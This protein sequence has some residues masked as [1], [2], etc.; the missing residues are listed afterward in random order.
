MFLIIL[1]ILGI[2]EGSRRRDITEKQMVSQ[3]QLVE[4]VGTRWKIKRKLSTWYTARGSGSNP[5][6]PLLLLHILIRSQFCLFHSKLPWD[7][8]KQCVFFLAGNSLE[9][10]HFQHCERSEHPSFSNKIWIFAPKINTRICSCNANFG[11]K[12]QM[13]QITLC[14]RKIEWFLGR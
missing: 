10:S 4:H 14:Q 6:S 8:S 9:K 12:I 3:S 1:P 11:M 2:Q 5:R 13:R 7:S